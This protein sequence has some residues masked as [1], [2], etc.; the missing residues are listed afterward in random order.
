LAAIVAI[1][2]SLGLVALMAG[3]LAAQEKW[4]W[5]GSIDIW[6][7]NTYATRQD[8]YPYKFSINIIHINNVLSNN[9]AMRD[10]VVTTNYGDIIFT[11]I[12]DGSYAMLDSDGVLASRTEIN[13]PVLI[14]KA[15]CT[16]GRKKYDVTELFRPRKFVPF[17]I[18]TR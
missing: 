9:N 15:T 11:D 3:P 18:I 14:L 2:L 17:Q 5:G 4:P 7:S 8:L 10:L 12:F 16:L 6:H 13:G 1:C